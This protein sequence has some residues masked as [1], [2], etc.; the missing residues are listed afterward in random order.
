M[1][2]VKPKVVIFNYFLNPKYNFTQNIVD[3][4]ESMKKN[5]LTDCDR[6]FVVYT[7]NPNAKNAI[8][9]DNI[10]FVDVD[11][12]KTKNIGENKLNKFKYILDC[13]NQY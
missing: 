5:Y 13:V 6:Q 12:S 4:Y 7:D 10:V 2:N 11:A 9:D 3:W 8:K 1:E